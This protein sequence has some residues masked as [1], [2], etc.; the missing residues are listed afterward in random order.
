M[1][2]ANPSR[3]QLSRTWLVIWAVV[4]TLVGTLSVSVAVFFFVR[5][6]SAARRLDESARARE[7][8]SA[9]GVAHLTDVSESTLPGSYHWIMDGKERGIVTLYADHTAS[10]TSGE[11]N[12]RYRWF[13]QPQGLVITWGNSYTVF[14]ESVGTASYRG[15]ENRYAVEMIKVE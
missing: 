9:M 11:R 13:L 14:T 5:L 8:V 3:N 4:A 12:P 7:T 1:N 10:G 2:E 6:Q 15:S